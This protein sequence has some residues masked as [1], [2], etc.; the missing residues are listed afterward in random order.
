MANTK[1]M[2]IFFLDLE[3]TATLLEHIEFLI[4]MRKKRFHLLTYR[5]IGNCI[6]LIFVKS[7]D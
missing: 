6:L 7:F 4:V 2:N 1:M 3:H 5:R